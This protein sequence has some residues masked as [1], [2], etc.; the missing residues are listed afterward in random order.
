MFSSGAFSQTTFSSQAQNVVVIEALTIIG[1]SSKFIAGSLILVVDA[2]LNFNLSQDTNSNLILSPT[3]SLIAN[4]NTNIEIG[5]TRQIFEP[6][7]I[8]SFSSDVNFNFTRTQEADLKF[9]FTTD[10]NENLIITSSSSMTFQFSQITLY[11][12]IRTVLNTLQFSFNQETDFVFVRA[13]SSDLKSSFNVEAIEVMI[14]SNNSNC[15]FSFTIDALGEKLWDNIQPIDAD[16]WTE[17]NTGS[18]ATWSNI[19]PT[20]GEWAN[21][22]TGSSNNW[23][24]VIPSTN[25]NW[26]KTNV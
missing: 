17:I 14:F 25:D 20:G 5:R 1:T 12:F 8:S 23:S 16:S 26:T 22:S 9:T 15:V 24:D 13:V 21:I 10:I 18:S 3:Q 6:S 2:T 19:N 7:L 4:S 11:N